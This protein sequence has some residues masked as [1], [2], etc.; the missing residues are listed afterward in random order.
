MKERRR[1]RRRGQNVGRQRAGR[2]EARGR[3]DEYKGRGAEREEKA[4]QRASR[5]LAESRGRENA[6]RRE[7]LSEN[8]L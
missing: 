4:V 2:Q 5:K 1:W 7:F 6:V 8:E 3:A